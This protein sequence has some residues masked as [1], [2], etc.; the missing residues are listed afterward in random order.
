MCF[1][2]A[3]ASDA[4]STCPDPDPPVGA[5]LACHMKRFLVDAGIAASAIV[6]DA[7][8]LHKP[9][10][11]AAL[12]SAGFM[13]KPDSG[14]ARRYDLGQPALYSDGQSALFASDGTTTLV[15]WVSENGGFVETIELDAN[16]AVTTNTIEQP[17]P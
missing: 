8:A 6:V 13:R 17:P 7:N 16:G 12:V 14:S 4:A 1:A 15:T 10:A 2:S 11:E 5:L 9:G 3:C